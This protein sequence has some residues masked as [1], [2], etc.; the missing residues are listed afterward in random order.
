MPPNMPLERLGFAPRP[1]PLKGADGA[2]ATR[3]AIGVADYHP[4]AARRYRAGHQAAASGS[5]P[6]EPARA[7][8]RR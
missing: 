3:R 5:R 7:V 8:D 2:D 1:R 6:R 4:L